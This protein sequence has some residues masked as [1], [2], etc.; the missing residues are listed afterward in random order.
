MTHERLTNEELNEL[1]AAMLAH[2]EIQR[3]LGSVDVT[4]E[5]QKIV[6]ALTELQAFRK[7]AAKP[8]A[9]VVAWSSPNEERTCDIRWRQFDVVPG[10]L[11]ALPLSE[12]TDASATGHKAL[13]NTEQ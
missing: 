3:E 9:D 6:M 13:F 2:Y 1:L 10:L 8:V 7:A 12:L 5:S 4:A 11:F